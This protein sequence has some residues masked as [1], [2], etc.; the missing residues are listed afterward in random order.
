VNEKKALFGDK[1]LADKQPAL[2][3]KFPRAPFFFSTLACKINHTP[4][5]NQVKKSLI[6][7]ANETLG[8]SLLVNY[9]MAA[10]KFQY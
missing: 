7:F 6:S 3:H 9:L 2:S 10:A 4:I 1:P 5:D 8:S